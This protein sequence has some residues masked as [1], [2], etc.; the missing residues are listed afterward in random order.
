MN[1]EALAAIDEITGAV[2]VLATLYYF[3]AQI[4]IQNSEL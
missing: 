1:W 4:K 2:A 3:A